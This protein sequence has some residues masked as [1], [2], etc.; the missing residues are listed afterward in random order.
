MSLI[1]LK[2]LCFLFNN[3]QSFCKGLSDKSFQFSTDDTIFTV[4]LI[5]FLS[6]FQL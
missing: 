5:S 4:V 1:Y 3:K 6:F 2:Y